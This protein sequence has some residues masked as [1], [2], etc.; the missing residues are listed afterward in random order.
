A[1]QIL[2]REYNNLLALG[3]ERRLDET[4]SFPSTRPKVHYC[5]RRQM[6]KASMQTEF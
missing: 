1:R 2:E 3:T 4:S 5:L 6:E